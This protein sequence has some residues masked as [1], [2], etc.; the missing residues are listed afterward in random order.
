MSSLLADFR[1]ELA[2]LSAAFIW[3]VAAVIYTGIGRQLSPL[4]L[5]LLKGLIAIVLLLLTLLLQGQLFPQVPFS[6]IVLLGLSG[7]IGI[8]FGDTAYFEGLN[9]LG[10]RRTLILESLAP[11]LAALLAQTFLGENLT[12]Q[13][14]I[15][16]ILTIVGV[17]WVVIERTPDVTESQFQPLRGSFFGVLAALGQAGGAVL[18]RSALAGTTIN[19]L[20]S[21][22]V[23]LIG[24][25]LLLLI[26]L[27]WQRHLFQKLT[28]LRSRQLVITL[29]GTA[30]AST[31]LGIWLQQMSLK[32]AAT[33]IA[34]SLTSTSPLFV[35]PIAIATGERVSLRAI[36]GATIALAGIW[37]LLVR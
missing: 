30:F 13:A 35:L 6:A 37:L 15:G 22:F 23:R 14:W 12:A 5:N 18:S 10:A 33:G 17:T 8:G 7:V 11:P 36:V 1:G 20:W 34:Q 24:G 4:M 21:A 9:C 3:A 29:V 26:W 25:V 32:Y 2:A 27:T 16:I 19:P 31:Y 28:P